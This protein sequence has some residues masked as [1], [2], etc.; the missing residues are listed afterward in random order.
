MD[1]IPSGQAF[2]G[3]RGSPHIGARQLVQKLH[4]AAPV[5]DRYAAFCPQR[6]GG[7][8]LLAGIRAV[9]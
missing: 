5:I 7:D 4:L 3:N 6:G 1:Q 9:V 8:M 2:P